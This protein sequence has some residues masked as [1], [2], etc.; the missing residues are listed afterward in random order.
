MEAFQH[1]SESSHDVAVGCQ[2]TFYISTLKVGLLW[3]LIL[4]QEALLFEFQ[5]LQFWSELLL[6][7]SVALKLLDTY[8][9]TSTWKLN[10]K[11]M[12]DVLICQLLLFWL[13][14]QVVLTPIIPYC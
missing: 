9:D 8:L 12:N 10:K 4:L 3:H 5:H 7:A 6:E 2:E 13:N 14:N 11:S 1:E